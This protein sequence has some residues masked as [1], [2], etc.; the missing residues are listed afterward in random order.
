MR[1]EERLALMPGVGW[2]LEALFLLRFGFRETVRV[3]RLPMRHSLHSHIV[4]LENWIQTLRDRLTTGRI[5][6]DEIG[7]IG[8][9][10]TNCE[11]AL[12]HY[13]EAYALELSSSGPE[14]PDGAAGKEGGDAG[15]PGKSD[16]EK[17]KGGLTAVAARARKKAPVGLPSYVSAF[18]CGV[19]VRSTCGYK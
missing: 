16:A 2:D 7:E 15:G 3:S 8:R 17:K 1:S 11:L 12:E 10:L 5:G 18:R 19:R 13:R 4:Y 6:A 14:M 9:Q